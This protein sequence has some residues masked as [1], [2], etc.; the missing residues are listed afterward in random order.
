[1]R[2]NL[3]KLEI[4]TSEQKMQWQIANALATDLNTSIQL[5][6]KA[7]SSLIIY[8]WHL[9]IVRVTPMLG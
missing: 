9:L 1:M 7:V 3:N 6:M 8:I 5:S 2:L 4:V